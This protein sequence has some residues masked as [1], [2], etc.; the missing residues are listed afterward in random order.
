MPFPVEAAVSYEFLNYVKPGV[1]V[2]LATKIIL[3]MAAIV[4]IKRSI[5]AFSG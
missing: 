1:I 4:S 2:N 5:V 3:G